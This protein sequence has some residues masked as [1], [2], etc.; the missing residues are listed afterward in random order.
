MGEL[1]EIAERGSR[2]DEATEVVAFVVPDSK[3][4]KRLDLTSFAQALASYRWLQ[5][6]FVDDGS[7][8]DTAAILAD[9]VE[10]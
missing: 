1:S 4:A 10:N 6:H 8:Y 5:L 2:G 9:F 3:E 7:Q